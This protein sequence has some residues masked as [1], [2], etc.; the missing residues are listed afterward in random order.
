M[1]LIPIV[2]EI[3]AIV[4]AIT[5]LD[6][7]ISELAVDHNLSNYDVWSENGRSVREQKD[8]KNSL[9]AFYG[10]KPHAI[11]FGK[12][13]KLRCMVTNQWLPADLVIASH[14]WPHA[15]HGDGLHKFNL[16]RSD[17]LSVRNGLLMV[18][19]VEKS[20]DCKHLCII[21]DSL[22][23]SFRVKVLNPDLMNAVIEGTEPPRTFGEIDNGV[24]HHS[25]GNI[26]FRRLLSWHARCSFR[27][28]R[29]KAWISEELERTFECYHELSETA[30]VPDG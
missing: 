17:S 29:E 21:Y 10:R 14:I 30:S 6:K 12:R 27:F 8:F 20:F 16:T 19:S 26:P 9:C 22:D 18:K 5:A 7:R 15:Q 2:T 11:N 13:G 3:G 23:K 25:P 4:Q 1:E 28:A 24:L